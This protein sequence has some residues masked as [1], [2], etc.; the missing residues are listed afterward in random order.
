MKPYHHSL[1]ESLENDGEIRYLRASG[2]MIK[3]ILKRKNLIRITS[4]VTE[5]IENQK[6]YFRK[7]IE[8]RKEK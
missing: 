6:K 3:K 1:T 2:K 4:D 7:N 8:T 5:E